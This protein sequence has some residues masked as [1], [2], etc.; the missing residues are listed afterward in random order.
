MS[1]ALKITVVFAAYLALLVWLQSERGAFGSE[2]GGHP[3]E[4]AHFVKGLMVSEYL[5]RPYPVSPV[6]YTER[7]FS[8]F[9]GA[10]DG[11][12]LPAWYGLAGAWHLVF[13]PGIVPALLLILV[14][15]AG[16]AALIFGLLS[17]EIG[18]IP[19][20]AFGALFLA[21]PLIRQFSG[22]TMLEIPTAFL[23]LA[24]AV[25]FIQF[26]REPTLIA[27]LA[28][29]L[30]AS[31][32]I[33]M[34]RAG[35][36]LL[37][38]PVLAIL[39]SGRLR[40][41]ARP[42]LLLAIL[43]PIELTAPWFY[44]TSRLTGSVGHLLPGAAFL[45]AAASGRMVARSLLG[46]LGPVL[47]AAVPGGLFLTLASRRSRE[48]FAPLIALP[49]ALL[50]YLPGP[51]AAL[52]TRHL[53]PFLPPLLLLLGIGTARAAD[54]FSKPPMLAAV[55]VA[56]VLLLGTVLWSPPLLRK[57]WAGFDR[58]AGTLLPPEP[59]VESRLLVFS[60]SVGEGVF[61]SE[62]ALLNRF[63]R[64]R[65]LC[66]RTLPFGTEAGPESLLRIL[67]DSGANA[68]AI[69]LSA[70]S[71]VSGRM[72]EALQT[73]GCEWEALPAVDVTRGGTR[74]PGALRLYR[75]TEAGSFLQ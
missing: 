67:R 26:L 27:S 2:L 16:T 30:L 25:T 14:F 62:A 60:D 48:T 47:L 12:W 53:I 61:V 70:R 21:L 42:L 5:A 64:T 34:S 28:Y 55:G 41:F 51:P 33:L 56:V 8:H 22:M 36:A 6:Q 10:D 37:L 11:P 40:L 1:R 4:S 23:M 20:F 57:E 69:D 19:A 54:R 43:L 50:L 44:L 15:A 7:F 3:G 17:E 38:L 68:V 59:G 75:R 74:H 65:I 45:D 13:G 46:L 66:G 39:I 9:P 29:A 18:D 31:A 63:P 72:D 49:L 32:A 24:A 52:E 35:P 71:L 73:A 58:A